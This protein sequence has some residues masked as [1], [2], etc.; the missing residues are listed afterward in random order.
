MT[1]TLLSL[2]GFFHFDIRLLTIMKSYNI[3]LI[4]MIT[5]VVLVLALPV[6]TF[7]W[8]LLNSNM[9][10]GYFTKI[11][12]LILLGAGIA[13]LITLA[14]WMLWFWSYKKNIE[15]PPTNISEVDY[16]NEAGLWTSIT[17]AIIIA[18]IGYGIFIS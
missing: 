6:S 12:I 4:I 7:F 10:E 1:V 13:D 14:K 3:T 16:F 2:T 17:C 18:W 15:D 11:G 9:F 8:F 5:A